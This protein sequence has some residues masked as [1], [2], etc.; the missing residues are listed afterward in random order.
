MSAEP[1]SFFLR[2]GNGV[3]E[4]GVEG[5]WL[6]TGHRAQVRTPGQARDTSHPSPMTLLGTTVIVGVGSL[7]ARG[8][9]AA[10][11]T[12]GSKH[13]STHPRR[14]DNSLWSLLTAQPL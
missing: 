8:S 13:L 7:T 12:T 10:G 9:W 4:M 14:E 11:R 1:L 6:D 3:G 2:K 5:P